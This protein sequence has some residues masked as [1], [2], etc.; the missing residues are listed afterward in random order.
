MTS[1]LDRRVRGRLHELEHA[2]LSTGR[3]WRHLDLVPLFP[4]WMAGHE[5]FPRLLRRPEQLRGMLPELRAMVAE[6]VRA[7]LVGCGPNHLLALSGCGSL[8]GVLRVS[9]LVGD[10]APHVDGRL[11]LLFPG[12]HRA[13][14][15]QLLDAG[16]GWNY[17]AV[18]IPASDAS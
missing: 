3:G 4:S 13:G 12:R 15:Y 16:D 18:P 6:R 17:G 9:E 14:V 1:A 7:E 2:T 8:F 5:F 10:V 11:L